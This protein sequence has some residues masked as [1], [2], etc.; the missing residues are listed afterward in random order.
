M[1][2]ASGAAAFWWFCAFCGVALIPR[3]PGLVAQVA[4]WID[5]CA[6]VPQP[7]LSLAAALV[8]VGAVMGR[9]W[10]TEGSVRGVLQVVAVAPPGAGKENARQ[11][12]IKLMES[13]GMSHRL[14][15]DGWASSSGLRQELS[16]CPTRLWLPDELGRMLQAYGHHSAGSH[17]RQ[18]VDDLLRVWGCAD[19]V[20]LG[21]A[22]AEKETRSVQAPHGCLYGTTTNGALMRALRGTD[23]VDG[24]FS[25]WIVL[26]VDGAAGYVKPKRSNRDIPIDLISM[27]KAL[28]KGPDTEGNLAHLDS[29]D[30]LPECVRVPMTDAAKKGLDV[31]G[32]NVRVE[33][34][35]QDERIAALWARARE[36]ALRVALTV[37]VG[38]GSSAVDKTDVA[39]AWQ[40]VRNS[41]RALEVKVLVEVA[42]DEQQRCQGAIRAALAR[43]ALTRRDLTRAIQ[44]YGKRV[45]EE[46]LSTLVEAGVVRH[47]QGSSATKRADVYS[48][49]A[50][51]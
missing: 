3:P 25:R 10:E 7:D 20:L 34:L 2:A 19:G 17:E 49:E 1:S 42:D 32:E 29:P 48:L 37:A 18:I 39:W 15:C 11:C 41:L 46:A 27:L 13:I 21:K 47:D 30:V 31:I 43:G 23:V 51:S 35:P 9:R 6:V 22:Y 26:F 5:S 28:G 12:A 40:F 50:A 14:G 38:R 45:R 4:E 8:V 16:T 44:K 36:Q 24:L 33:K